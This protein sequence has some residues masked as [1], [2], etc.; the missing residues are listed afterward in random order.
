MNATDCKP[1]KSLRTTIK[2]F[3]KTLE[4][5]AQIAKAA[6]TPVEKAQEAPT[7]ITDFKDTSVDIR[8]IAK[9]GPNENGMTEVDSV[10]EQSKQDILTL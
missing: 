1:H 10:S 3:L 7:S 2:V 9:A 6:A 5:K 4:K 8:D